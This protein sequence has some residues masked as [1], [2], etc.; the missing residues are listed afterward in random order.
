[1]RLSVLA[2]AWSFGLLWGGAMLCVGILDW[3][4][5]GYGAEFLRIMSSVYPGYHVSRSIWEV[6]LGALYGA[7]DGAIA[8]M[9]AGWLYNLIASHLTAPAHHASSGVRA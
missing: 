7:V 5:P 3:I 2:L 9:L 1:M 8:G 4:A 6:L